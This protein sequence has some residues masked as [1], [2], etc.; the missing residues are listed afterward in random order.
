MHLYST[1]LFEH[2]EFPLQHLEKNISNHWSNYEQGVAWAMQKEGYVL[3][4]MNAVIASNLPMR[5]GLAS[6]AAVELAFSLAC[7]LIS[8]LSVNPEKRALLCQQAENEFVGVRCGILDQYTISFAKKECALLIDFR[9]R[10]YESVAI[11]TGYNLVICDTGRQRRLLGSQY[12]IR[13]E[14]CEA[15]ASALG[16]ASLRDISVEEFSLRQY[17]LDPVIR[18]RSRHVLTENR[19]VLAAAQA[20][21]S[22]KLS[23]FSELM[24]EAHASMRDDYEASCEELEILVKAA[25]SQKGV[26]GARLTGAGF[27]GCTINLV[28]S[29]MVRDFC[30]RITRTY[31]QTTGLEPVILVCSAE[32][33][34]S[35][36]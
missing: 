13:R 20:L 34:L 31:F 10:T 30:A 23:R 15:A 26:A 2:A 24:K 7:Q 25:W 21:Q 17:E 22:G 27:G 4:G 1:E 16:V 33:G 9:Q 14:E 29:Q 8:D 6:S 19:R 35:Q 12:N 32:E 11:P 28:D 18:K 3:S 36:T 5:V